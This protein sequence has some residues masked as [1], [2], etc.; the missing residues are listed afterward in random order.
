MTPEQKKWLDKRDEAI[1]I[2]QETG[3][4]TMAQEIGLFPKDKVTEA[5]DKRENEV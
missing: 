5:S 4:E 1:R 3:D 2:Y